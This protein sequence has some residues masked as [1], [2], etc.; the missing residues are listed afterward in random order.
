MDVISGT[1]MRFIQVVGST[2][3]LSLCVCVSV[4]VW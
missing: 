4:C 3:L 1:T 2:V